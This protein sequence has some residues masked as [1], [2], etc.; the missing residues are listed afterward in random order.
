[1]SLHQ[2]F[3]LSLIFCGFFFFFVIY[4][5]NVLIIALP[6]RNTRPILALAMPTGGSTT[7]TNE[8]REIP[9]LAA[10]KTSKVFTNNQPLQYIY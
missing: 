7:V 10:D 3:S 5:K 1:M 9:L 6:T 4:F 8:Q 2:L